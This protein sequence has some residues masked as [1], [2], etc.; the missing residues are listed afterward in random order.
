[1]QVI[2][3]TAVVSNVVPEA[4]DIWTSSLHMAS[5]GPFPLAFCVTHVSKLIT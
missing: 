1:M 5:S 2:W 4:R 3:T